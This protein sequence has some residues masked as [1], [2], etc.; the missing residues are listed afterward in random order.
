MTSNIDEIIL[1]IQQFFNFYPHFYQEDFLKTCCNEKRVVAVW[2]R[3]SGKSTSISMY[4][5][6][7]C[8]TNKG[9]TLLIFAPVQRQSSELYA[10]IRNTISNSEIFKDYIQ[11]STQTELVFKNGS[12]ILS[13]PVGPNGDSIRGFTGDTIILEEAEGIKD[14]IVNEVIMPMIASKPHGQMIKI[15]TGKGKNH[16]WESAYGKETEY[17]LFCY[18]WT[19]PVKAKQITQ[20]FINEQRKNLTELEFSTEYEAKFIEDS[21]CYF[22]QELIQSCIEDYELP[23][24]I[25][26]KYSYYLGV[27]FARMGEDKSVFIPVLSHGG[28]VRVSDIITTEHKM[29]TDA[30]GRVKQLDEKYSFDRI[31]L[32]QTGLGAGPTDML[33]EEFGYKVE[34]ITFTMQSKEDLYSNLKKMMEQGRLKIPNNRDLY[35]E[36]S[37]LRYEVASSGHLKLHHSERGHDDYPDALALAC[38]A[39]KDEEGYSPT[40]A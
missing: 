39:C 26:N 36:L 27:D 9:W 35:Y 3:Q 28:G 14:S 32:D 4:A 21:D 25:N 6:Y 20:E 2:C 30:V 18:D 16:F 12:R 38:W 17:K 1:F 40:L 8:L 11:S 10:K 31:C 5:L 19:Y 29:L 23:D 37:D 33:T 34:G 7:K 24:K 13:L 22:K 15:G